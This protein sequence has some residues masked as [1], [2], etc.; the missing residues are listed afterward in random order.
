MSLAE[1]A[2]ARVV[3]PKRNP[4]DVWLD[5]LDASERDA[6][7]SMLSNGYAWTQRD[8]VDAFAEEGYAVGR[9]T[10]ARWRK[11]NNVLSR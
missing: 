7:V 3:A 4:I 10:V 6:A 1:K 9:E 8:I 5:T 11:A 2:K